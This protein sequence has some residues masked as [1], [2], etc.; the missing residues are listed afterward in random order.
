M[1]DARGC[2]DRIVHTVA[3]LVFMR[4]GVPAMIARIL[5]GRLQKARHRIKT[6]FGISEPVYGDE[7]VPIQG[8]GQGNGIA[9]TAWA[10]ISSKT[11][12]VTDRA[13]HGLLAIT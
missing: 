1:N 5:F 3:I 13:G 7:K 2:F 6:G 10:L 8:S 9:S 12:Q 11:F 4:F